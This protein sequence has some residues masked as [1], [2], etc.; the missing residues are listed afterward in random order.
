MI[1]GLYLDGIEPERAAG[2]YE[3]HHFQYGIHRFGS[4]SGLSFGRFYAALAMEVLAMES[5]MTL[6]E[7]PTTGSAALDSE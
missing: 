3:I 6:V 2:Q 7:K 5:V 1:I 4:I